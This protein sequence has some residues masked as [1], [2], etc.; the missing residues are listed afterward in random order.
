MSK[1][2]GM[3]MGTLALSAVAA[4]WGGCGS[5]KPTTPLQKLMPAGSAIAPEALGFLAELPAS[6]SAFGVIDLH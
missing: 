1:R 3:W 2:I 5:K 6:T 4:V